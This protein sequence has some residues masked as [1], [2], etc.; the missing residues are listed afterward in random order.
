MLC[1]TP[2]H[3]I[4]MT[5]GD[6]AQIDIVLEDING[7]ETQ[8]LATDIIT[9][10]VKKSDAETPI[11]NIVADL[12]TVIFSPEATKQLAAGLYW[13][14]VDLERDGEIQTIVPAH[15]FELREELR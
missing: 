7:E 12:N 8:I 11:L 10:T 4:I 14:Q 3:K 6:T 5:K 13:Y 15:L 9:L 2:N 1:I